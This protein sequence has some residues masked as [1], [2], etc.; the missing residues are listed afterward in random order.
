MFMRKIQ[1]KVFD[2][3]PRFYKPEED[4]VERR[5]RKLNFRSSRNLRKKTRS[6]LLWIVIIGIVIFVYLKLI[7]YF[8]R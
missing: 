6:P 7:G 4:E 8:G 3:Q 2:Y 5:K 1:N